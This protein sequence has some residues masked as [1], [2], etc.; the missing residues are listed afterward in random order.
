MSHSIL[1]LIPAECGCELFVD[2]EKG[3]YPLE[4]VSFRI[5]IHTRAV[6]VLVHLQK[7]LS[8]N[9]QKLRL[10]VDVHQPTKTIEVL[11]PPASLNTGK[12]GSPPPLQ[13]ELALDDP[14]QKSI[15]LEY[16]LRLSN[17]LVTPVPEK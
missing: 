3:H 7:Q 17:H 13:I 5:D 10:K 11:F 1:I 4:S 8:T 15:V 2:D 16:L 6:S 12:Y 14:K 9:V